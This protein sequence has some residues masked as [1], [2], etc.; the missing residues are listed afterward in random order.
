MKKFEDPFCMALNVRQFKEMGEDKFRN[1]CN[2]IIS[3]TNNEA[4]TEI[5]IAKIKEEIKKEGK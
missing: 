3:L 2:S 4:E 1:W 5:L